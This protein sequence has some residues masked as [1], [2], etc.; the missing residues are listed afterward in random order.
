MKKLLQFSALTILTGISF[1]S[2]KKEKSCEACGETNKPPMAAAGNDTT[3]VLPVDSVMLDGSAS[4]DLDGTI[5]SYKWSRISGPVSLS[6][7]NY[8]LSKT[9]V[10][11]FTKGVYD[12]EL[13]V[14]DN[15]GMSAQDTVQV[16]VDDPAINHPPTADA[17]ADTIIILPA[18]TVNLDGSGST[19]TENSIINYTWT[20]ISGPSSFN[21]ANGNTIQSMVTNLIQGIYQFE[22]KVADAGGLVAKDTMKVM[23]NNL[24]SPP[25][26]CD[27]RN[28]PLVQAQLIPLGTLSQIRQTVAV[29]AS[30][31]KIVFAGGYVPGNSPASDRVDIYDIVT[32]NWTIAQIS[33]ARAEI[34]V[35]ILENRIFLAGGIV[36]IL[37][38]GWPIGAGT[39]Y[40]T[41]DPS[42]RS[43]VIDIYDVS[44]N[45]WNTAQLS[46]PMAPTGGS[47]D[48]KVVFAGGD[49]SY[50]TAFADIYD[51]ANNT[52][53]S[54][55]LSDARRV[56]SVTSIDHKIFF[57]GGDRDIDGFT[58][59]ID[60]YD[61]A[62]NRWSV[63]Y[64]SP[65]FD[66]GWAPAGISVG[67]KNYW[68]GGQYYHP[69]IYISVTEHVEIRDDVT[70]TSTFDCLSEPRSGLTV[71]RKNNKIIF[72][73][74]GSPRFDI[75]DLSS[76]SWSIGI[77]PE[78]LLWNSSII[79]HHN[80]IYIAGGSMDNVVSNKVW[81]LEF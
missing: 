20:K 27:P 9:S 76:Q 35:A 67:G 66:Q 14:T 48:N 7:R 33:Q 3:I 6:I 69:S 78:N 58:S 44:T 61:A 81:K 42:T 11:A 8:D 26:S 10:K 74:G 71:V 56:L 4:V 49:Y 16:I 23:V 77:L 57:A 51:A 13:T 64:F 52:W 70:H 36:P 19:D 22:L 28:R 2:C 31:N 63:N 62:S 68:A 37:S 53:S 24:P 55:L 65:P 29:A 30:G 46:H 5:T 50:P 73:G 18:N 34:G 72:L 39:W 43:S 47:V 38:S 41:N 54:A 21:L 79:S 75:Y 40:T 25:V 32:G 15:A 60:I 80:T 45:T 59:N 1:F 17:G 12:F